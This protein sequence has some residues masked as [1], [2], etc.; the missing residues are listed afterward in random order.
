MMF[1]LL[2]VSFA[3]CSST[4]SQE[5]HTYFLH[6]Y[7]LSFSIILSFCSKLLTQIFVALRELLLITFKHAQMLQHLHAVVKS[8]NM[9]YVLFIFS[10]IPKK[11]CNNDVFELGFTSG[12][13]A[14]SN[15]FL[16]A[17]WWWSGAAWWWS[18]ARG[19]L[20]RQF[21]LL[22]PASQQPRKTTS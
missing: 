6:T 7:I 12:L 9:F 15:R 5:H 1:L 11:N 2:T 13:F 18:G 16:D 14:H 4:V 8:F 17:A 21:H 3:Y 22:V 19:D 10:E 20:W